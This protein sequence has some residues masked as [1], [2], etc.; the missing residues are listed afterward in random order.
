MPVEHIVKELLSINQEGARKPTVFL[1]ENQDDPWLSQSD[2]IALFKCKRIDIIKAV[3]AAYDVYQFDKKQTIRRIQH[4][5]NMGKNAS[6]KTTVQYKFEVVIAV[7]LTLKVEKAIQFQQWAMQ[8]LKDY[9]IRGAS[10]NKPRLE[11]R[12]KWKSLFLKAA[13]RLEEK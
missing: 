3:K 12:D 8:I 4:I 7:G 6:A 11:S 2:M 13:K 1:Q 10:I 9:L 5:E